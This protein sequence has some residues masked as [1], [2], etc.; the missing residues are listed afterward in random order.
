MRL[1]RTVL[2]RNLKFQ[3]FIYLARFPR[4]L[5]PIRRSVI[6][7]PSQLPSSA[8]HASSH[9]NLHENGPNKIFES[10]A[11]QPFPAQNEFPSTLD[12]FAYGKERERPFTLLYHGSTS[13]IG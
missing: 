11:S 4:F 9:A 3:A 10:P 1:T 2:V 6:F 8:I 12:F 7:L 5:Q 13:H